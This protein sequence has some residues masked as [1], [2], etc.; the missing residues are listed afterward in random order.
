MSTRI[1][2]VMGREHYRYWHNT[3][4]VGSFGAAAAAA[5]L[6]GLDEQAFAH[7]L[8]DLLAVLGQS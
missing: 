7:A 8:D 4:S 1:G 2:V 3:G 6:Y 5:C